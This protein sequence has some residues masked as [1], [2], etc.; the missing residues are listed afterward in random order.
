MDYRNGHVT[1]IGGPQWLSLGWCFCLGTGPRH[2]PCSGK[3]G[4]GRLS[5]DPGLRSES[6]L[7]FVD[8]FKEQLFF[9][10]LFCI[11]VHLFLFWY[12]FCL[13][14]VLG[15]VCSTFSNVL[16]RK[17]TTLIEVFFLFNGHLFTAGHFFI[18]SVCTASCKFGVFHFCFLSSPSLLRFPLRFLVWPTGYQK[19]VVSFAHNGELLQFPSVNDSV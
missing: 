3:S 5:A 10:F 17:V 8:L 6:A 15:L 18:S 14:L 13:L 7:N 16:R 9:K 2:L 1:Q 19:G 12:L 11:S 4:Q